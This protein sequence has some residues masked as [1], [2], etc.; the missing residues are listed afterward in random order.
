M[1][2]SWSVARSQS[3]FL[4]YAMARSAGVFLSVRMTRSLILF[5]S[6]T[7]AR[8]LILFQS[9]ILA[10]SSQVFQSATM[11][12]LL[13]LVLSRI[14]ARSSQVFQSA[15]MARFSR[16]C[17]C[18]HSHGFLGSFWNYGPIGT[19]GSLE[20]DGPIQRGGSTSHT[21]GGAM[22]CACPSMPMAYG[23]GGSFLKWSLYIT[24]WRWAKSSLIAYRFALAWICAGGSLPWM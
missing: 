20:V 18:L 12:R 9:V 1:F 2:L 10:R 23:S 11:A 24:S 15:T 5:L 6:P 7:M 19:F 14:M 13:R 3:V 22:V 16:S 21:P 17:V 8:S 4:S